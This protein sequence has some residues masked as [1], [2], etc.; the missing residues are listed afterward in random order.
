MYYEQDDLALVSS[1]NWF[2]ELSN[3]A[4]AQGNCE[5]A[6][7]FLLLAWMAYD[8]QEV[9]FQALAMAS[10]PTWP[11]RSAGGRHSPALRAD[12]A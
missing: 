9:P 1:A 8:G 3:Q 5:R 10:T 12:Q 2:A 4:R 11:A 7:H 6:D